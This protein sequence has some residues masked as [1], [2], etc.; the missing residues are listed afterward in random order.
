MNSL[1]CAGKAPA[2]DPLP[3]SGKGTRHRAYRGHAKGLRESGEYGHYLGKQ[4][5]KTARLE[6]GRSP[7]CDLNRAL[8]RT[9]RGQA[10]RP[11]GHV[12]AD[13]VGRKGE[14]EVLQ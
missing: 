6:G 7:R 3:K 1:K 4:P 13:H 5:G 2:A 14:A 9:G 8:V 11:P 10:S 12:A